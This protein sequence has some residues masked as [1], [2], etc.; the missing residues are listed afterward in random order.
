MVHGAFTE[1]Q[2]SSNECLLSLKETRPP[3]KEAAPSATYRYCTSRSALEDS[4]RTFEQPCNFLFDRCLP[5]SPRETQFVK[6]IQVDKQVV[7]AAHPPL[8]ELGSSL[9]RSPSSVCL[10]TSSEMLF[11]Q[12]SL[13][14]RHKLFTDFVLANVLVSLLHPCPSGVYDMTLSSQDRL[15]RNLAKY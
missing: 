13:F 6:P 8:E 4:H 7:W 5:D 1:T 10:R 12:T 11:P 14:V 15:K 2:N 9:S 3:P